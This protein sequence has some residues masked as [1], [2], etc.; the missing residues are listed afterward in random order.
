MAFATV[1]NN[2]IWIY[3]IVVK[4]IRPISYYIYN[5]DNS[6]GGVKKYDDSMA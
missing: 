5:R 2:I 6:I 1:E 3:S 4:I